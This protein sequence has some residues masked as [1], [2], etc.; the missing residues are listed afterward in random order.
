[1]MNITLLELQ[2]SYH[3]GYLLCLILLALVYGGKIDSK[4]MLKVPY[5]SLYCF[6]VIFGSFTT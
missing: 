6:F 1:M 3:F 4:V 2:V 5:V